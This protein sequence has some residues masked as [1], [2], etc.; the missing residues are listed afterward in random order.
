MLWFNRDGSQPISEPAS[1]KSPQTVDEW[2]QSIKGSKNARDLL[3]C[4]Q[5]SLNTDDKFTLLNRLDTGIYDDMYGIEYVENQI[6]DSE[7]RLVRSLR[8]G[9]YCTLYTTDD[10]CK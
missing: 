5:S 1:E 2:L 6:K 8:W 7:P 4:L 10:S 3:P 9:L